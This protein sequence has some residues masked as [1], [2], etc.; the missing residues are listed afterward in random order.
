MKIKVLDLKDVIKV[1]VGVPNDAIGF[2]L[3]M[4]KKNYK[5]FSI[6]SESMSKAISKFNVSGNPYHKAKELWVYN[7]K[8]FTPKYRNEALAYIEKIY[9]ENNIVYADIVVQVDSVIWGMATSREFEYNL[10]MDTLLDA[11]TSKVLCKDIYGIIIV[12][13]VKQIEIE[14]GSQVMIIEKGS[15]TF[16]DV[17]EVR[18]QEKGEIFYCVDGDWFNSSGKMTSGAGKMIKRTNGTPL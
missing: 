5:D 2:N 6:D 8:N 1:D 15:I 13:V 12:N 16:G 3:A 7:P 18:K 17:Q 10:A 11:K 9:I 4:K 14:E